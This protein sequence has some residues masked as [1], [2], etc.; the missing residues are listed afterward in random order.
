MSTNKKKTR[1]ASGDGPAGK[2]KDKHE[3]DLKEKGTKSSNLDAYSRVMSDR[4]GK[5]KVEAS[6]SR[7]AKEEPP[8]VSEIE[9][10]NTPSQIARHD[11]EL[12]AIRRKQRFKRRWPEVTKVIFK[13]KPWH[14]PPPPQK[15]PPVVIERPDFL[16]RTWVPP[17]AR[18]RRPRAKLLRI[19]PEQV[20]QPLPLAPSKLRK[21][22]HNFSQVDKNKMILQGRLG[23][24]SK[25]Y[26]S[27]HCANPKWIWSFEI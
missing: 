20:T 15:P 23:C 14:P 17:Y 22:W 6:K 25:K 16:T 19:P 26:S 1:T 2:K 5:N 12:R 13:T 11:A 10:V 4:E 18:R 7:M 24:N 3:K 27:T 9:I 8:P 21:I